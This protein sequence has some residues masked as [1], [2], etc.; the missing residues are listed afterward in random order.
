MAMKSL[1]IIPAALALLMAG[2]TH[3]VSMQQDFGNSVRTN[4][5]SQT[6]DPDAGKVEA[7]AATLDGQKAEQALK[8]YRKASGKAST[9]RIIKDMGSE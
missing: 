4:I 3:E 2:C 9:E 7:D 1:F 5:A 6:I 8:S